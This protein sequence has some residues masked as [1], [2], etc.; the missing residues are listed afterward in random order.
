M[1]VMINKTAYEI[2]RASGTLERYKGD[3]VGMLI[4]N[5]YSINDQIRL[6]RKP[7]AEF[8]AFNTYAEECVATVN[9]WFVEMEE[10]LA[11]EGR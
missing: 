5:K 2:H 7:D 9:Q 1:T 10:L 4:G 3:L 6:L 11:K 8:E